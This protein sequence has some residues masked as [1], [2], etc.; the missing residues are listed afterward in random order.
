MASLTA[1]DDSSTKTPGIYFS[2]EVLSGCVPAWGAVGLPDNEHGVVGE[3]LRLGHGVTVT[4]GRDCEE[5]EELPRG[6]T[7]LKAESRR[8]PTA[9]CCQQGA[10]AWGLS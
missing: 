8:A 7:R 2:L 5:E 1:C 3:P 9:D 6:A 4:T 10:A